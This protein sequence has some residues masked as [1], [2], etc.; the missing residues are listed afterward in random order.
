MIHFDG[1][2]LVDISIPEMQALIEE[3]LM[4][5]LAHFLY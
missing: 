5:I 2:R 4:R 1:S 3:G